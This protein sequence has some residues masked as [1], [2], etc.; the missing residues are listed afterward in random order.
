MFA[1]DDEITPSFKRSFENI[2]ALTGRSHDT[3]PSTNL[4]GPKK[5]NIGWAQEQKYQHRVFKFSHII[6]TPKH[7]W[8][9]SHKL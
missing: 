9:Q 4:V 1:S 3:S 7:L 2:K 8:M 6:V 5:Y